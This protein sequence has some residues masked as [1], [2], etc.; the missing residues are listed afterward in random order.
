MKMKPLDLITR[1]LSCNTTSKKTVDLRI[2]PDIRKNFII[3]ATGK[4]L[5]KQSHI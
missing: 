3:F 4:L 5:I 1:I 2:K